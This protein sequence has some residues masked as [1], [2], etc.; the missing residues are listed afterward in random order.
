MVGH[1]GRTSPLLFARS[2]PAHQIY[3]PFVRYTTTLSDQPFDPPHSDLGPYVNILQGH[4]QYLASDQ[5]FLSDPPTAI[6]ELP[7]IQRAEGYR[8]DFSHCD[9]VNSNAADPTMLSIAYFAVIRVGVYLYSL[10]KGDAQY[11][12]PEEVVDEWK[13]DYPEDFAEQCEP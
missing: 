12:L 10:G 8:L 3:R 6:A 11:W 13:L 2:W 7:L 5:V 9:I 4:C 1:G